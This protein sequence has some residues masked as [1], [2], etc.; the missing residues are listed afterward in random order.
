MF[1]F[2]HLRYGLMQKFYQFK[3]ICKVQS[4]QAALE[5]IKCLQ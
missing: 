5:E 4:L 1:C 3:I 2:L